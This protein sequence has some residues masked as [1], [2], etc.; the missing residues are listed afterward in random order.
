MK[1]APYYDPALAQRISKLLG[2]GF[3]SA[4]APKNKRF[5]KTERPLNLLGMYEPNIEGDPSPLA[6][7]YA[8]EYGNSIHDV[9]TP[10]KDT[11]YN[12][13]VAP[14]A[15]T[16]AHEYRHRAGIKSEYLNRL[17]DALYAE[18]PEDWA[19]AVHMWR[20]QMESEAEKQIPTEDAERD[21]LKS[22]RMNEGNLRRGEWDAAPEGE[23][24]LNSDPTVLGF[25][26][27]VF[28][29]REAYVLRAPSGYEKFERKSR[30]GLTVLAGHQ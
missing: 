26:A 11:V 21:L 4:F 22:L 17:Y 19:E 14:D 1:K 18:T 10:E 30:G 7:P 9:L 5:I 25:L 28:G 29:P 3:Q 6:Y 8:T 23:K 20:D 12:F 16:F 27:Q 24:P 2:P 13:G 15:T